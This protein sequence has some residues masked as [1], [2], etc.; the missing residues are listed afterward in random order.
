MSRNCGLHD[1]LGERRREHHCVHSPYLLFVELVQNILGPL[2]GA[3]WEPQ[4]LS[5][6]LARKE[7]ILQWLLLEAK[8][9]LYC[10]RL[11]SGCSTSKVHF[12]CCTTTVS[13]AWSFMKPF[14][15]LLLSASV[16]Q[17]PRSSMVSTDAESCDFVV[18]FIKLRWH[19]T[20]HLARSLCSWESKS[21]V[22]ALITG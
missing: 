16:D 21:S 3:I 7:F 22:Y 19:W 14:L 5:N 13:A 6:I 20:C 10:S 17:C 2:M 8:A 4:I 11:Q 9:I 18:F 15:S 1:I 12:R